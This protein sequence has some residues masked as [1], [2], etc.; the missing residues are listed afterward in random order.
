[1]SAH[2]DVVG[3]GDIH[4]RGQVRMDLVLDV[5]DGGAGPALDGADSHQLYE[6]GDT[7]PTDVVS[8]AAQFVHDPAAAVEGI[9]QE[10]SRAHLPK[11][12]SPSP[13][14]LFWRSAPAGAVFRYSLLL[15]SV[16]GSLQLLFF[17]LG[18]QVGG[19]RRS[20]RSLLWSFVVFSSLSAVLPWP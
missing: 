11:N 1:M 17:P 2:Q 16:R 15:E 8:Q 14:G 13:A 20:R 6:L 9:C 18:D 7:A 4:A 19:C 5:G 3:N 10:A 12:H